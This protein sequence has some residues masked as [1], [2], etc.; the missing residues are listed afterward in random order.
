MVVLVRD[1]NEA[2]LS[3]KGLCSEMK[4]SQG[5]DEAR[6]S[7]PSS[8][9]YQFAGL[10]CIDEIIEHEKFISMPRQVLSMYREVHN[11]SYMGILPEIN[12]AWVTIDNRLYLWNYEQPD[13]VTEYEGLDDSDVI[14]SVALSAPKEGIFLNNITYVLVVAT[15]SEVTLFAV[16]EGSC[17]LLRTA[18][19]TPCEGIV[20]KAVGSQCG[21][22]FLAGSDGSLSEFMYS[23]EPRLSLWN[24]SAAVHS[25]RNECYL[26]KHG[27]WDGRLMRFVPSFFRPSALAFQSSETVADMVVDNM[28]GVLYCLS[29]TGNLCVCSLTGGHEGNFRQ[30]RGS[31]GIVHNIFTLARQ[32]V[33][34]SVRG[35][36]VEGKGE[37]EEG[38][39]RRRRQKHR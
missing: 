10:E 11:A 16:T 28:R 7:N 2:Y 14:V 8:S 15:L 13:Q 27:H 37:G 6:R 9:Q 33:D 38:G 3:L 22:I 39:R 31:G 5:L 34:T 17:K 21:R 26:K 23:A 19:S 35:A 36:R 1:A 4:R 12:R 25:G 32:W 20:Y 29:T 18:Y 30:I 24:V